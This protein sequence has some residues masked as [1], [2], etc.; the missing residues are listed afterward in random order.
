MLFN[1]KV[2]YNDLD[3]YVIDIIQAETTKDEPENFK[4]NYHIATERI[5]YILSINLYS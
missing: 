1:E 5:E 4:E 3:K 2:I